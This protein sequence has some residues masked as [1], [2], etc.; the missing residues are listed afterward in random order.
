MKIRKT[1]KE[2]VM[3]SCPTAMCHASTLLPNPDGSLLCAWFGGSKEGAPDV[4][5]WLSR[6]TADVWSEPRCI[7]AEPVAHWNPVLFSLQDGH[8]LLFYKTG[9]EIRRWQTQCLESTDGG[10]SWS[11]PRELVPGD[12]GG[13][14]PVRN[15]PIRLKSG[16]IL[17]PASQ[18]DGIW[19]AFIDRSADEG[20]SWQQSAAVYLAGVTGSRT[21]RTVAP[22]DSSI[23]V[24]EQSFYGRGVIQPTLWES[25]P[26]KVHMLLRS[27]EGCIC[28]S[29]S[30]DDGFSWS[31]A[32][33]TEMPNNNSGIDL[34]RSASGRL[35]LVCN[36]I[37]KNWGERSPITLFTSSDNGQSWQELQVLDQGAGEFSYPSI[38][39]VGQ[40]LFIS[41]TARRT[42]I[43]C[44][45]IDFSETD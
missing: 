7:T 11:A 44:W 31:A 9:Q 27:T 32:R 42:N 33:R 26:G 5:I 39:C 36:P 38:R 23:P 45:Q 12:F 19:R 22:A 37:A 20:R 25:T 8:I 3:A 6:R 24:S 15:K 18:E 1:K 2:A 28:R 35:F 34:D 16:A 40:T 13:R 17:A 4:Q 41:Y 43:C 21:E 10:T 14:G 29:D 30:A